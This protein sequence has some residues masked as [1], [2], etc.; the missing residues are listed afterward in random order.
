MVTWWVGSG[1]KSGGRRGFSPDVE[2]LPPGDEEFVPLL[3][4]PL[5]L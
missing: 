3:E 5:L 1:S 2:W 4:V